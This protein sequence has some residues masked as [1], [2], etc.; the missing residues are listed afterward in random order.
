[1]DFAGFSRNASG[2]PCRLRNYIQEHKASLQS[3]GRIDYANG[4]RN[5][6]MVVHEAIVIDE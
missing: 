4:L 6:N 3:L 5:C 1:V 2:P